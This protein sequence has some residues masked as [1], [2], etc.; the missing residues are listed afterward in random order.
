MLTLPS[1]E[2]LGGALRQTR[3]PDSSLTLSAYPPGHNYPWHIHEAP[4]FFVL[5]AGQHRDRNQRT[6][7]DQPPL[8]VVFHPTTGPHAT[9]VGPRGMVGINLELSDA[10]LRR[11]HLCRS[12]LELD[13]QLL[14]SLT[15]QLLALR[16]AILACGG[17][18]VATAEIE[19]IALELVSCLRTDG[20]ASSRRPAW[21]PRA[22]EYLRAHCN[23]PVSLMDVAAEV[24]LHPVYC[25]R[26][27]RRAIGCS[28]S[29][30]IRALGLANGGRMILDEG[31]GLAE[32][33]V[34]IGFADQAHFTRAFSRTLGFTPGRLQ[35]MRR[36][37]IAGAAA[38][39]NRSRSG[40]DRRYHQQC[41][42]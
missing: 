33:A 42:N 7:F 26:A 35:S 8:S 34:R 32:V 18:P 16:L 37:L 1:G 23:A 17:K 2:Y 30:Y 19:T 20:P 10:W 11:C 3:L 22:T 41:E 15:A 25:A 12:D 5:L 9:N 40:G 39:S 14:H 27:F 36:R 24:G 13:Y 21:L 31:R 29:E 4:T 6:S 38:G 28:M